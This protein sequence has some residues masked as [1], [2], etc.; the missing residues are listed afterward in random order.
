MIVNGYKSAA[1]EIREQILVT[2]DA[3][4]FY[5]R[6]KVRTVCGCCDETVSIVASGVTA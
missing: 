2:K 5:M 3:Q 6:I 1:D 4:C